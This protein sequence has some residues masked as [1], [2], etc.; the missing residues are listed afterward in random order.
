MRTPPPRRTLHS[1]NFKTPL[2]PT[3]FQSP[4]RANCQKQM[5]TVPVNIG[6]LLHLSSLIS[7]GAAARVV[8]TSSTL[9]LAGGVRGSSSFCNAIQCAKP[10]ISTQRAKNRPFGANHMPKGH[11]AASKGMAG[12]VLAVHWSRRAFGACHHLAMPFNVPNPTFPR[13]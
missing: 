9:V 13:K 11:S 6:V 5:R 3:K 1:K 10:H 8:R 7:N 12:P 4:I 2:N